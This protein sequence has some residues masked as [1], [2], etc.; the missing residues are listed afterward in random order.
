MQ[1]CH[2]LSQLFTKWLNFLWVTP[3]EQLVNVLK[4]RL[5][6]AFIPLIT[7]RLTSQPAPVTQELLQPVGFC[8]LPNHRC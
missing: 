8:S 5:D 1:I 2:M 7:T 6:A 3:C 4:S